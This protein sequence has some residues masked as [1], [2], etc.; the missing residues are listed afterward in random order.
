MET[1]IW[2]GGGGDEG[3]SNSLNTPVLPISMRQAGL[4]GSVRR[5]DLSENLVNFAII[6]RF[7]S[8]LIIVV[9]T[10]I[11][12]NKIITNFYK[13]FLNQFLQYIIF[14]I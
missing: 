9:M 11:V 10:N 5:L 13:W 4:Q 7:S 6:K 8:S 3:D 14:S 12:C 1:K 2:W